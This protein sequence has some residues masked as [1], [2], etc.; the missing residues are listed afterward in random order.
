[1]SETIQADGLIKQARQLVED[2]VRAEVVDIEE[3]VTGV[4]A[5][6]VVKGNDVVPLSPHVFDEWRDQPRE[7]KGQARL[8]SIDSLIAH[9]NRFKDDGSAIFADNSREAP[10]ITAVIDYHPEGRSDHVSPRFGRHRSVFDFPLS[11]EWKAW[12]EKDGEPM[13][14]VDFAAFL[15]NRII[16]VLYIIPGED[17]LPEDVQRLIDTLGGGDMVAS[18]NKLMELSRGLQINENA[19]VQEAVNLASGEGVVRFQSEHTDAHGAPV[20]VPSLFLIGIPVFANDALYR[21][22]AR[23]RYRKNGGRLSFWFE[24]W[25][26]DRTFDHAFNMAVERVRAE[27]ELPVFMG[28]PEA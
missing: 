16:D 25:R 11:D 6:A 26:T 5:L 23:L 28:K 13:S 1:M 21:I 24:L 22:A 15:E 7:R 4:T 17:S 9:V 8:L 27:T 12:K 18:P 3:P 14:M 19:V 20:K 10:S 2:Y